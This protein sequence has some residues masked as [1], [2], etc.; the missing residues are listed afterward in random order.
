MK[1]KI[2][3]RH[4]TAE[5]NHLLI[6][7]AM[8]FYQSKLFAEPP[9]LAV[10][11]E[12][13]LTIRIRKGLRD[14]YDMDGF[15]GYSDS[16]FVPRNFIIDLDADISKACTLKCL[17]HEFCHIRQSA[18]GFKQ[19]SLDGNYVRWMGMLIDVSKIHYYDTPWEIDAHGREYGLYI[20]FLTESTVTP[21]EFDD[22]LAKL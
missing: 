10:A 2:Q 11:K 16:P 15:S 6:R 21:G 4:N 9:E 20:R 14:Q 19:D 8:V 22:I 1:L 13:R 5:V 17:A 3:G 18:L 12:S 7:R